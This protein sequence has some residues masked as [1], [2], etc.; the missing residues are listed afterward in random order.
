MKN[1][2][3][4]DLVKKRWDKTTKEE[5]SKIGAELYKHTKR[6]KKI[7]KTKAK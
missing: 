6:A 5:R 1:K 4:Q 3:A 2:A 7:A